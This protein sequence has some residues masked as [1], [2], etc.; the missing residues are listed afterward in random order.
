MLRKKFVVNG[1][2]L[3]RKITGVERYAG[4]MLKNLDEMVSEG[5]V[6]LA[7]PPN[8]LY[9]PE[10]KKIK[11]VTVKGRFSGILWENLTF[12][13]F[14]K[15]NKAIS[16]NLCNTAPLI[17]PGVCCIH[18]L[19]IKAHP[20]Y[21]GKKFV[22]W[23]KILF[24]NQTKR[25]KLILTNSEFSKAEL[26]KYYPDT[27]PEIVITPLGW[28]HYGNFE[29]DENALIKYGLTKDNY[30][31][32]MSSLEPNKNIKWIIN[33]AKANEKYT[34]AIAGSVN[35]KV[36]AKAGGY[37]EEVIPRNIKFL[38]FI[39]D[40]EGKMLFENCK[41]FLYPTFYE[42]FGIPPLEAYSAGCKRVVV[43]D[44]QIMHEI[45]NDTA[46]FV[47]PNYYNE[48][49][50]DLPTPDKEQIDILLKKYT[51]KNGAIKLYNALCRL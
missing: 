17:N 43:S 50:D 46:F 5:E 34:F 44:T 13:R 28:D 19:K 35:E 51:W 6:I 40:E 22:K 31:F 1:R 4:E 12:V 8:A 7:V 49:L 26:L 27:K 2:F 36:F 37:E 48:S 15:K 41:A 23:Y 30:F 24:G 32:S 9:V 18:D 42:G 20:E 10:F 25:C 16:L 47:N 3:T 11:T 39:S 45:L 29:K 38:G 33:A 14:V 21:F